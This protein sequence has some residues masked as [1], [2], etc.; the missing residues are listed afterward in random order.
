MKKATKEGVMSGTILPVSEED[1]ET[2]YEM[3]SVFS[4]HAHTAKTRE[5]GVWRLDA[6]VE[7]IRRS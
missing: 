1:R 4:N 7:D 5:D 6:D 3:F 2:I